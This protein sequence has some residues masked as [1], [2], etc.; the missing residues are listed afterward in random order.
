[1]EWLN[2]D[3]VC[4]AICYRNVVLPLFPNL[5]FCVKC[6]PWWIMMEVVWGIEDNRRMY[7]A[8]HQYV[9]RH[10]YSSTLD[11]AINITRTTNV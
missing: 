9:A 10:V 8:L 1:M 3:K 4:V 11:K 5:G 6:V 2:S 7:N